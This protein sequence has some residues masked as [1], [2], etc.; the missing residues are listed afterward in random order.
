M[1]GLVAGGWLMDRSARAG[2]ADK[3]ATARFYI[4]QLLPQV[5]GL[6]P[7]VT[8]GASPLYQVDLSR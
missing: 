8:A 1:F 6:L 4:G 7:A 3:V 5:H 2:N